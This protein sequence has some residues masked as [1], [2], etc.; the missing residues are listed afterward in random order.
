[1]H[2][3]EALEED[4]QPFLDAVN[5]KR[6]EGAPTLDGEVEWWQQGP[7]AE[8][9]SGG[10]KKSVDVLKDSNTRHVQKYIDCGS[11]C[12]ANVQE[13]YKQDFKTLQYPTVT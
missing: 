4:L 7:L 1:M 9:A 2:R 10:D 6:L 5:A 8:D 12:V 11:T 13:Y 3:S